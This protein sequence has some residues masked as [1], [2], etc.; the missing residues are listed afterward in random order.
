MTKK[1]YF[2][3]GII[4]AGF[5]LWLAIPSA[6][7][8]QVGIKIS[9]VRT[10][11]LVD[12]GETLE[13]EMQVTNNSN[14]AKILFA[15][16]RDF[17]SYEDESGRAKL[18][19]PGSEEGYFLAS[20][21]EITTEGIEFAA[22]EKK[23]VPYKIHVPATAG[24]GGYYGAILFGTSPPKLHLDSEDKGAGMAIAQQ[25]G[26]LILLHVKGEVQEEAR[27]REFNT[28]KRIYG[29]PFDVEFV[30]RIEN[31]GN[32]HIKPQGLI[33]VKNMMGKETAAIRVNDTGGNI[34][35]KDVRRFVYNW[36][37]DNG[38]GR[39]KADLGISYGTAADQGGQGK[40]SLVTEIY[41]WIIPWRI[42]VPI[43]LGLVIFGGLGYL[44]LR[45]YRNKAVRRAL[46]QAGLGHV[47]YVPKF[48]GPSPTLHLALILL[49]IFV[50]IFIIIVFIYFLRF[51]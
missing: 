38:F 50:A 35:P 10:E 19:V 39:Y 34:L 37:G 27:I 36:T 49:A 11:E 8:A 15:Y 1:T 33:S 2:A 43:T 25:T 29:T 41:F 40:Q 4:F 17:K 44:L 51:A 45:L 3:A 5:M 14:E 47:R 6:V 26:S 48:Q 20:W 7:S 28:R 32:V 42:I 9:P 23:T 31:L 30:V 46:E 22:G 21:I 16:L 24:P 13:V 12:P 18:I